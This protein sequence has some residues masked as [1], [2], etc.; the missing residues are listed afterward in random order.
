LLRLEHD[1]PQSITELWNL[2]QHPQEIGRRSE[3]HVSLGLISDNA[4]L[5]QV[6]ETT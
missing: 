2:A 4:K 1:C 3:R 6:A 5:G